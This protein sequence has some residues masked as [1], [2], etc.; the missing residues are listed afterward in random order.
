MTVNALSFGS[1]GGVDAQTAEKTPQQEFLQ[2]LVA[3][4]ENQDPLSPQDG[5]AFVA[6]LA[7]FT[8]VEQGA[9]ANARL[10]DLAASQVTSV[11][12]GFSN[13]VGRDVYATVDTLEVKDGALQGDLS[14]HMPSSSGDVTVVVKDDAGNTVR[15]MSLGPRTEGDT[16]F[17][18]PL[19]DEQGNRLA[20]GKYTLEVTAKDGDD[21]DIAGA[22]RVKGQASALDFEDGNIVFRVGSAEI[23]PADI[24]SIES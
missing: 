1:A 24:I 19:V 6:Q 17:S 3:Q 20:D 14:L 10:A 16:N 11:R 13:I 9:E 7:Q 8:E 15:T 18:F 4:L 5:A 2:L 23:T 12:A 22:I 21:A